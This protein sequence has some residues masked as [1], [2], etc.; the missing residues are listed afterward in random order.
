MK[1]QR[2]IGIYLN[3]LIQQASEALFLTLDVADDTTG[4][5]EIQ[6]V[7]QFERINETMKKINRLNRPNVPKKMTWVNR[8]PIDKSGKT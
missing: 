5:Y 8:G 1:N 4:S 6:R 2:T 3:A 7:V